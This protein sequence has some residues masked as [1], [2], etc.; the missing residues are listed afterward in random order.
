MSQSSF[1]SANDLR[2][3]F[4]LGDVTKVDLDIRW[5]NGKLEKIANVAANHLVT[6]R[7]GEG[8]IKSETFPK[9]TA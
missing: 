2:L 6:I 5:P 9:G 8:V 1:Y 4:G 3:H 7:E